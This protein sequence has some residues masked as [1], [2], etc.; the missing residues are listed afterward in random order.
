MLWSTIGLRVLVC[1][2]GPALLVTIA[3]PRPL[4]LIWSITILDMSL[5]LPFT[6]LPVILT[7]LVP[8]V[9]RLEPSAL[10]SGEGFL[11]LK[12]AALRLLLF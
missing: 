1:S 11:A 10:R 9:V 6:F 12:P 4:A 7:I 5:P 8:I 2:S 3:G